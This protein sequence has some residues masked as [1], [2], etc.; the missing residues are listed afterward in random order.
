[1]TSSIIK[2]SSATLSTMNVSKLPPH[3]AEPPREHDVSA[4]FGP[5]SRQDIFDAHGYDMHP[6]KLVRLVGCHD[7]FHDGVAEAGQSTPPVSG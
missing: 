7:S 5:M 1:M 4:D 2:S 6:Q 3:P